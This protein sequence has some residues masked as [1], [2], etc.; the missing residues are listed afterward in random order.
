MRTVGTPMF[1]PAEE[2][3]DREALECL[4]L[5]R[6][7]ATL[8]RIAAHNPRYHRHLGAVVPG[9]IRAVA[10][11]AK[12]P[13]LTKNQLRDGYPYGF[14]CTGPEPVLRLQMSSGTTGAPI[15]NPYTPADIEQWREVMARC[16]AAATVTADD[17]IQIAASFGLFT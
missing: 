10:D 7:R 12:L 8:A 3:R 5:E 17:V 15:V 11:L 2:S 13:F 16:L 1:Q 4:Q 9:D 14:A 6:L